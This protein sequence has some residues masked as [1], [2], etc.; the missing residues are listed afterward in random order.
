M[1]R[2]DIKVTDQKPQLVDA[3]HNQTLVLF[4]GADL[5]QPITG[6]PSRSDLAREL[7]RRY[8]IAASSPLAEVAARVS[9]AGSRFEFTDF[10]YNALN[11]IEKSPQLFHQRIADLVKDDAIKLVI[12][13]AYD[14][15]LEMAFRKAVLRFNRVVSGSDVS[16]I[17]PTLPTLI[18]FYG[19]IEQPESLVITDQDHSN[20]LRDQDKEALVDEVRRAFRNNTILFLGYNLADPDFRFLFDQVAQ[21]RFAR[22]A[23]AVWPGRPEEDAQMWRDRGIVILDKDPFG[24][25]DEPTEL[26]VTTQGSDL[27]LSA[28]TLPTVPVSADSNAS[29]NSEATLETEMAAIRQLLFDAFSD[30][31]LTTFCFDYFLPVYQNFAY[32][33]SKS[34]KIQRLLDYCVRLGQFERL[35]T[36]VKRQNPYQ[37]DR[38]MDQ[39]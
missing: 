32:G 34:D 22:T 2:C 35:L 16:F 31:E 33:M 12:T 36:L 3:R 7:G 8:G 14:N 38:Y 25:L 11:P 18:K 27:E 29:L 13:V 4:I 10:I 37:F 26:S 30:D 19:D 9:R 1:R 15:L 6:L 20:L 5:P 17:R 21:D 23:F 39:K 24:I 28:S